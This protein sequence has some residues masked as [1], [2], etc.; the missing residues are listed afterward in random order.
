MYILTHYIESWKSKTE[1]TFALVRQSVNF[2][3]L[4]ARTRRTSEYKRMKLSASMARN[5]MR[6]LQR[7]VD[8]RLGSFSSSRSRNGT[9]SR[10]QRE[11]ESRKAAEKPATRQ[12]SERETRSP[13]ILAGKQQFAVIA[14]RRER[15]ELGC[16]PATETKGEKRY[17]RD[18]EKSEE[19]SRDKVEGTKNALRVTACESMPFTVPCF[20]RFRQYDKRSRKINRGERGL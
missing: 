11:L 19:E 17:W 1:G 13:L 15:L 10:Y 12:S 3:S 14:W 20:S 5:A 18:D 6:F 2:S 8:L 9:R 16:L 7:A 4:G